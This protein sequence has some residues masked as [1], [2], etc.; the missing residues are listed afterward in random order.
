MAVAG[1]HRQE[2]V[3]GIDWWLLGLGQAISKSA[4]TCGSWVAGMP[5]SAATAKPA[6][7][8]HKAQPRTLTPSQFTVRYG[9][10]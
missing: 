10:R 9:E 2:F 8:S 7:A 5:S 1:I 6:P 4:V 3:H